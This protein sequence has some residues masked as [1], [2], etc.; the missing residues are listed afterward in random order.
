[1]SSTRTRS[2]THLCIGTLVAMSML[3]VACGG[4]SVVQVAGPVPTPTPTVGTPEAPPGAPWERTE[5]RE[6]CAA[7]EITRR[8]YFG[9][10]HV[11]TTRS[12]DAVVFNVLGTPT[13]AYEFA[14]GGE[15]RLAPYDAEGNGTRPLKLRRPLDFAA[16]TDHSEGFGVYDVCFSSLPGAERPPGYEH[17]DCQTLRDAAESADPQKILNAFFNLLV[18]VVTRYPDPLYPPNVCG[19]PPDDNDCYS[20][21]NPSGASAV[22]QEAQ[23]NAEQFYDRTA[24]C[25]FTSF[26]AYEWSGTP[27]SPP[28]APNAAV[29]PAPLGAN[30]HR[31]VIF[32]NASVPELPVSYVDQPI[33]QNL[34][35]DLRAKCQEGKPACDWLAIPHNSNISGGLMFLTEN[36]DGSPMTAGDAVTRAKSE[37]LVEI[38]QH[39]GSSECR[40]GAGTT[41]EQCDF[42]LTQRLTIFDNY[43][44]PVK[45]PDQ[46][47]APSAALPA[48]PA[49]AFVREAFKIGLMKEQE[50]GTNPFQYGIIASTDT[51]NGIPG[52]TVEQ[53]FKGH[54]G[55]NDDTIEK[56]LYLG[57]P[58]A[59]PANNP[60]DNVKCARGRADDGAAG[61]AVAWAEENSRDA[62]F[63]AMRR[64][65]TYG[66]SG[67]RPTLRFFAGNYD[68]SICDNS[69]LAATGYRQGVPMGAE[70][71][72]FNGTQSPT[73]T[74]LAVKDP[75]EPSVTMG[76]VTYPPI[77]GTP[78]Q[79]VQIIKGWID[80]DGAAQE[81]VFDVAGGPNDAGVDLTTCETTGT[82]GHD[83]LCTA[84]TDPEFD[85]TQRAF[86]YARVLENPTCRWSQMQCN[87]R[88]VDCSQPESVPGELV[89]CCDDTVPK[90]HQERAWSSPIWYR[91]E[92]MGQVAGTISFGAE[93]AQDTL[94]LTL[95]LGAGV[96]HDLSSEALTVVVRDN[97]VIYQA[98][99]PAGTVQDGAYED[100]T[101]SIDGV[102]KVTFTQTDSGPATLTLETV[103]TDL[104][105]ADRL[106]HMVDVE[107]RIGEYTAAQTR[108]WTLSDSTLGT[109]S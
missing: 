12:I 1:M 15:I 86:Y 9:D 91:P 7:F 54:Q 6:D 8:P 18:P 52:A 29:A 27:S 79:R 11:H 109:T 83:T 2:H 42:E 87:E 93:A 88:G 81:K 3:V 56:R 64:R 31:N 59:C 102:K 35:E 74:V 69:D 62:I 22:W 5:V 82:D 4:E 103:A 68:S 78:L 43:R 84:W 104:S 96:Q 16:V 39:K 44:D 51:H 46:P 108:M 60:P 34:W 32:R 13:E 105:K 47:P 95:P 48:Y 72:P 17:A 76:D 71:G 63:S 40:T 80:G 19:T 55:L 98:T 75:G 89:A 61:L 92:G 73:F 85:P 107:V 20:T 23:D 106:T 65:E 14:K 24:E 94:Q 90:T 67:T 33:V 77:P 28:F 101:G 45:P 25:K 57:G 50:L 36:P 58:T 41:D 37:P 38:Y 100:D 21:T 70:I 10:T 26:V 66:T 97:D 49:K 30:L 53:D 99:L